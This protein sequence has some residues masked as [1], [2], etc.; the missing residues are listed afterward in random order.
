M[1]SPRYLSILVTKKE[2]YDLK[3]DPV[4]DI[5]SLQRVGI[6]RDPNTMFSMYFQCQERCFFTISRGYKKRECWVIEL[7]DVQLIGIFVVQ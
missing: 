1:C 3:G 4:G 6:T 7:R 2:A 5:I